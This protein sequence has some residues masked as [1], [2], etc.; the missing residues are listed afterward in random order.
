MPNEDFTTYT[1][2]DPAS[3][4][5]VTASK[6][7]VDTMARNVSSWLVYDFGV[8]FF[9]KDFIFQFTVS[10]TAWDQYGMCI[11][12]MLANANADFQNVKSG[13]LLLFESV[14]NAGTTSHVWRIREFDSGTEYSD[15]YVDSMAAPPITR[16]ITLSR[17]YDGGGGNGQLI[18]Q[19][20]SGSHTGTLL[21]TLT[22]NLHSQVDFRYL[23]VCSSNNT[24][25]AGWLWSGYLEN[26]SF[27]GTICWGHD[28]GVEEINIHDF[29]G[30]WSG[31]GY[32]AG[33]GDAEALFLEEGEY[34]ESETWNIGARRIK[35]QL[36][37][38][39]SGF[40]D[41]HIKIKDGAS[42]AACEADSWEDY[43]GPYVSAGWVKVRIET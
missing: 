39:G 19:I 27:S 29:S 14:N 23:I 2:T 34:M 43:V 30:K 26:L 22:L 33:A 24:G 15:S 25:D 20:R 35:V 4:L 38:Y 31:T 36:D 18:A 41:P 10:N 9:N 28:T 7:T 32:I 16:Y 21:D 3:D 37:K 42:Q 5:T 6:I 11:L 13:D 17:D 8:N 1:E 40:G 12:F